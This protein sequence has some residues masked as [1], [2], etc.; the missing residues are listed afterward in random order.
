[1][2]FIFTVIHPILV[3]IKH[4]NSINKVIRLHPLGTIKVWTKFHGKHPAVVGIF[5]SGPTWCTNWQTGIAFANIPTKNNVHLFQWS[6]NQSC[7]IFLQALHIVFSLTYKSDQHRHPESQQ[8]FK[9]CW[10][11]SCPI[12]W[13]VFG[14]LCSSELS[15]SPPFFGPACHFKHVML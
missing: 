13:W 10:T 6:Q 11:L 7:K 3:K 8:K 14:W 5:Q 9:G 12:R 4:F 15:W 2:C 1:M